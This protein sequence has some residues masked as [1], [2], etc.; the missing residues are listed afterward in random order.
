MKLTISSFYTIAIV[1][2]II[3]LPIIII[4]SIVGI[5]QEVRRVRAARSG[6]ERLSYAQ[7]KLLAESATLLFVL[8][9]I[10]AGAVYAGIIYEGISP[11][12]MW[13]SLVLVVLAGLCGFFSLIQRIHGSNS[14]QKS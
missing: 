12:L 6:G 8:I 3:G 2:C 10:A 14:A 13:V 7:P 9:I 5:V 11:N 4:G 1:L